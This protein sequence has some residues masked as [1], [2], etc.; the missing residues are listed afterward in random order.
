MTQSKIELVVGQLANITLKSTLLE[1]IREAQL[2]D[3]ELVKSRDRVLARKTS[4]FRVDDTGMLRFMNHVCMPMDDDIKREIMNESHTTPYS[5]H[6]GS[7]KM[8]QDFK[9]MFWWPGLLQPLN[10]SKWKWEDIAMDF[11]VGLPRTT[12]QYDSVWVITGE[13]KFLGPEAVQR[14]SEAVDKIQVRMLMAQS[15]QKSYVDPKWRDI[16]F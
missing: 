15:R 3:R 8:Y 10:I 11:V 14:T 13:R 2:Q 4:D 1:R 5:I 16:D 9:A 12:R 7:T 6:P